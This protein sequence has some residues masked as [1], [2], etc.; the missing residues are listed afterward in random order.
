MFFGRAI[1][2][3]ENK[4]CKGEIRYALNPCTIFIFYGALAF[5][6]KTPEACPIILV[7]DSE[8]CGDSKGNEIILE[9]TSP[10]LFHFKFKLYWSCIKVIF[11]FHFIV[12]N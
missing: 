8:S 10:R 11:I 4:Y 5:V 2:P 7:V 9:R 12:Q 3:I 6:Q 1:I